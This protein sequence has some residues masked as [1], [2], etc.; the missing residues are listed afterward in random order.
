[1]TPP[2]V[3]F[4][5][6]IPLG[7]KLNAP[8]GAR[9]RVGR[10]ALVQRL[11]SPEPRRLTLLDAPAG[12]GKTSLL[13]EWSVAPAE[14][15]RFAWFTIDRIDNDPVRFWAYVI[16]ALRALAPAIGS[17]SL[18]ALGMSGTDPLEVVLPP[19]INELAA[20][21]ERLVLVMDDYH[22]VESQEVHNGVAFLLAHLPPELELAIA[23]RIDPPL[24]LASLRAQGDML[25]VRAAQLR[26]NDVEAEQLL[27]ATIGEGLDAADVER[28]VVRTEG[29]AA[30]LY[31]AALSLAGRSDWSAFIE[32]FAGDDRHI[33]DYLGG[34]VLDDLEAETRWFLLRTSILERLSAPLCDHLLGIGDARQ[35]LL[36]IERAN[37][38]LVPL[39]GR[40][41][42][43]RYHHLFRELLRQELE[44]SAPEEVR[45]LHGRAADWLAAGGAID[46]A[47]RH[48]LAAG[49]GDGA[50]RL[51]AEQ[52]RT[53]FNRGELATVDR[54]LDDL[55]EMVVASD[56]DLCLARA[57]VLM[58]RG[59]AR[60][61]EQWLVGAEAGHDD[62]VPHAVLSF[63]LGKIGQAERIARDALESAR[64]ESSLGLGVAHCILGIA[65]YYQGELEQAAASL[66]Q[67][68]LLSAS[69]DNQLARIYALGYLALIRLE[70]GDEEAARLA[71]AD[72]LALGGAPPT[73]EH[74]VT[75]AALLARG[76]LDG[77]EAALQQAVALA[78]RGGAPV[79]IA[80][81]LLGLGEERRDPA[82]LAE[83]RAA[84]ESCED[85][86]RLPGLIEQ[87]ERG[88]R[89]GRPGPRRVIAGDLS[90]RELAV[91]RLLPG[92]ASLREIASA[93]YVSLN[94]V[95]THSRS[96]YR[97][98]DASSRDEAVE[99][100]R[101]LGLL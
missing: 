35:R 29:W 61:A 47:I 81:S 74:F 69:R 4:P 94:T 12:W 71:A 22:L 99:R 6:G 13:A 41:E 45:A 39:D 83:A 85:P 54:W 19:L 8:M 80:A 76:R 32:G 37:L 56:P 9:R 46:D 101:E 89:G 50:A 26:F 75:S 60:E 59:R 21:D 70:A 38:F 1:M 14:T 93:L 20:L 36:E 33:V 52:W 28:L 92:D 90:D 15:R 49:D 67:A 72:A 23:T 57:W 86:G 42:W 62:L 87:A 63:K 77:D 17:A 34:E 7:T 51:V 40:R 66:D 11:V 100:G 30:G 53:P 96:I 73:S 24:P 95:K 58:D 10:E 18:A 31:L 68:A 88:L 48:S 79:E 27:R 82:T 97:K 78:R 91:L 3:S 44:R 84:L 55:P 65:L 2:T 5:S 98:L 25:E 16:E 64:V 43:Y